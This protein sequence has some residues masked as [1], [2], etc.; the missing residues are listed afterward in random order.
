M[1]GWDVA[2][3]AAGADAGLQER[4]NEQMWMQGIRPTFWQRHYLL[5][6]VIGFL[7]VPFVALALINLGP[8]I[9][10]WTAATVWVDGNL[11]GGLGLAWILMWLWPIW[12]PAIF[13]FRR[14]ERRY[15]WER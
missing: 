9:E 7:L 2:A 1:D 13:A 6:Y 10:F 11:L 3:L 4:R 14:A 15:R 5:P 8:L 12:L